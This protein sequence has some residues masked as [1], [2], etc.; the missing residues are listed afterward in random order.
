MQMKNVQ[1]SVDHNSQLYS[2][3]F[4]NQLIPMVGQVAMM[5][6]ASARQRVAKAETLLKL[7]TET[8]I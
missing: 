7:D 3:V 6:E 5:K 4:L 2:R 8:R 1:E